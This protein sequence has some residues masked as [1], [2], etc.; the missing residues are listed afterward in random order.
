MSRPL[1]T[2]RCSRSAVDSPAEARCVSG[3]ISS[4]S[5]APSLAA[6]P[7]SSAWGW[8]ENASDRFTATKDFG[9]FTL[10]RPH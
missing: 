9:N 5:P 7:P 8:K 6:L 10:S 2:G 1:D 3:F 4:E